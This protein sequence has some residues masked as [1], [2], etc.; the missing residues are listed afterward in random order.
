MTF[1]YIY[2]LK[3]WLTCYSTKKERN[4]DDKIANFLADKWS[5]G[6][7]EIKKTK[8]VVQW[9]ISN[10]STDPASHIAK[11]PIT[12]YK[13]KKQKKWLKNKMK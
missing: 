8:D 10:Q 4:H 1:I 2:N 6:I 3:L 12:S 7:Q 13:K 11:K 9:E 5:K